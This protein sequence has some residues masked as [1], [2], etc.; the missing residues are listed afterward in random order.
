MHKRGC[1]R[2]LLSVLLFAG[3]APAL[4]QESGQCG[5]MCHVPMASQG[6]SGQMAPL[7][8]RPVEGDFSQMKARFA[9]RPEQE[10]TW[11]KFETAVTSAAPAV[12]ATARGREA[13]PG[14]TV[15]RAKF[16][17]ELWKKRYEQM[18]AVSD[19]FAALYQVLDDTQKRVADQRFGYCELVRSRS[20]EDSP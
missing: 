19:A 14:T 15:E 3:T 8:L 4:A 7:G 6:G 16:M 2:I 20:F 12:H 13:L 1:K 11:N 5:F 17:Q 10:D 18:R 9:I